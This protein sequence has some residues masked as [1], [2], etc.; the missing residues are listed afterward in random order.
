LA[1]TTY[2]QTGTLTTSNTVSSITVDAYGRLTALTSSLIAIDAGQITSGI[3]G[4]ARGGTGANTFTT[5]GVLL[6]QGTSSF[7][8]ASSSTEGHLLTIN[9]SGI[10]TFA[11]LQGGTF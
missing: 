8:T 7:T 2:V 3:L 11:H 6:G 1:N 5:N 9:A 4:V 10:P